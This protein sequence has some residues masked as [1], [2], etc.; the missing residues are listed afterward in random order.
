[1]HGHPAGDQVLVA[2]ASSI[3]AALR[4]EDIFAR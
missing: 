1:V 2:I 3:A 4:T